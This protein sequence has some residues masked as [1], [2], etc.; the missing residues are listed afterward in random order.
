MVFKKQDYNS[1]LGIDIS[2]IAHTRINDYVKKAVAGLEIRSSAF[3][4]DKY[5]NEMQQRT[6]THLAKAIEIKNNILS[7]FKD[8]LEHPKK[9]IL[10]RF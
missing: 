6:T 10:L 5:E 9:N 2:K 8:L 1:E 4:I 7:E 3:L